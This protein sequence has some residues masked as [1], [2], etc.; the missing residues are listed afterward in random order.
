MR[1]VHDT[2]EASLSFAQIIDHLIDVN[3]DVLPD[4]FFDKDWNSASDEDYANLLRRIY[5]HG[6]CAEF[7][8]AL[9]RKDGRDRGIVRMMSPNGVHYAC[10]DEGGELYDASGPTTVEAIRK[11]YR[12][13]KSVVPEAISPDETGFG[14]DES[15]EDEMGPI[16][17][18][19]WAMDWLHEHDGTNYG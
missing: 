3:D 1:T 12:F 13:P 14:H 5:L 4:E 7:A 9:H 17:L 19:N 11:R 2:E 16:W 10:Q 8:Y 6:S 18:A 15:D